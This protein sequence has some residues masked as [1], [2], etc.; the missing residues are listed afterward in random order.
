MHIRN[1][2]LTLLLAGCTGLLFAQTVGPV[3]IQFKNEAGVNT[4]GLEFSPTFYEDGI[5]F[6]ST[7]TAG[8][9][10]ETDPALKLPAMS[11]LRSRR[12]A[13]GA[14]STPE[15]FAKELST[16]YHEGPVCFDRTAENVYFS[17]NTELNGKPILAADGRQ[18]MRIYSSRK[19]GSTWGE[20]APLPFN[21]GEFDDCHPAISIDGDKLFFSSNRPGGKGGMDLYVSYKVGDSW[22]E[23]VNLGDG[24]NTAGNEVFPFIHAD[25]T[26]YYASTALEENK[27]GLDMYFVRPEGSGWTKPANLGTPF[28]TAGD[29]F[30]LIV[31]LNKINGYYSSNG[32]GGAGGDEIFNFHTENGTLDDYLLQNKPQAQP[33]D[34][35]VVVTDKRTGQPLA[36]A[37]VKITN[38]A[39]ENVIGR[40]DAG[41]LITLQTVDGQDVIKAMTP[42]GGLSGN[43][44]NQGRFAGEVVP[45]SYVINVA[46]Q[47]YQTKQLRLPITQPGNEIPVQMEQANVAGK[48]HW[49]ASMF[50]YMTNAPM[51]GAAVVLTNQT[52]GQRDTVYADENGL[53]DSYLDPNTKYK[54]DILQ[55]G[56]LVGSSTIDTQGWAA[57]GPAI[58][59]NFS[60]APVMPGSKIELPN[61]YYNF[62]DATLRPDARQDLNLVVALMRQ[63]PTMTVEL[64]SHTD[65]RGSAYYNQDLSQRRANGVVEYLTSQGIDR[66]RLRPVGYGESEPRNTCTD[67]EAC[68]EQQHARNRRTEM[69][70]ISGLQAASV[71]YVDGQ[72]NGGEPAPQNAPVKVAPLTPGSPV[73]ASTVGTGQR[74]AYYVIAGSFLM[75][76]RAQNRL[77]ELQAAGYPDAEVIRFPNSTF[78]SVSAGKFASRSEA[79]TVE[80]KLEGENNIEAFV[81]AVQ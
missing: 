17:R 64:A 54:V 13:E 20:P 52:T 73:P 35:K 79:V 45:G 75:E 4:K 72:I 29:D 69:R 23:P 57:N 78:Y 34:I 39:G 24:V 6:I 68:T 18:K 74:N 63:Q 41:N 27:G 77:S 58:T 5:V 49:Q 25:G 50:N 22:S 12:D 80:K 11:I 10:K 60:V 55:G 16:L 65:C 8:L 76:N 19:T 33:V 21:F 38:A 40:D 1:H 44:D 15:P 56:R 3:T 30:G 31:D 71:V 62:N 70:M 51:A 28:N 32:A 9:K 26:L 47:G 37:D 46:K 42:N 2:I 61:I 43:T 59:Q 36:G 53:V 67:G 7:N 14:L 81:R 48:A 66:A